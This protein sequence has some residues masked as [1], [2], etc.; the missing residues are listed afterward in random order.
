M[1]KKT[2]KPL[3]VAGGGIRIAKKQE[4]HNFIKSDITFCYYLGIKILQK[5]IIIYFLDQQ[6]GMLIYPLQTWLS[7]IN[8]CIR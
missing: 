6:E 1:L 7:T 2:K 4:F 8:C 5:V 3:I